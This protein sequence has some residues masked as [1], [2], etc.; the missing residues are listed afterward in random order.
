MVNVTVT[1]ALVVLVNVPLIS[2][3]PLAARPVTE[4]V[5]SLVQPKTV[6]A[7]LP[8][9]AM[10]VIAAPEH[11]VCAAGVLTAFGIGLTITLAVTG[12]PVQ[13]VPPLV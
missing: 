7:T 2:P 10:V 8:V 12:D 5:L 4:L 9:D 3:V 6:P 1:G 13:V 11:L